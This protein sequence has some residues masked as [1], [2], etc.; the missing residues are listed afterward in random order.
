V[1][2]ESLRPLGV[3]IPS[4]ADAEKKLID[5]EIEYLRQRGLTPGEET[6]LV[7][8]PAGNWIELVEHRTVR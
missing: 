2:H 7:L 8:D 1:I 6:L 3:E 4:L 5:T